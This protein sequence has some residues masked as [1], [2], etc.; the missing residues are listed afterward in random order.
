[1]QLMSRSDQ[2]STERVNALRARRRAAGRVHLNADVPA[3]LLQGL[4]EIKAKRGA[5][6]RIPLIEEA[7]RLLIEKEMR[8]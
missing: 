7:L 1:M 8:A 5:S 6:S 4:D 3:E 2:I